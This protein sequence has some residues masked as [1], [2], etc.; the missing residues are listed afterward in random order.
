[1]SYCVNC[2]VELADSER[3]CPLCHTEVHN[4]RQP[5]DRKIP[6]HA[7]GTANLARYTSSSKQIMEAVTALFDRIIDKDLLARRVNLT[8]ANVL[9]EAA[10]EREESCEQLD[11]FSTS[12]AGQK[13]KEREE[14]ELARERR[15]QEAML[16]IKKKFGKNAILK[17]MDLQE[18]A[19]AM[20]RN[21]RIGGHKA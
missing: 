6:K 16:A 10:V 12:Q 11:F 20:D 19:T 2:G 5:Y 13:E 21:G 14:V 4:P 18:D 17:E 8:A 1:M 9:D 15:R 3:R 7:H